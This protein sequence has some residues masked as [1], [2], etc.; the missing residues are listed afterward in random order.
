VILVDSSVLIDFLEGREN[1]AVDRLSEALDSGIPFGISPI[2]FL[3]ILQGAATDR[4]FERLRE[5]LGTQTIY[6]LKGGLDSY[7]AAA[8]LFR[9]LRKKGL[10]VGSSVD[11]L[12]ARTAIEHGLYLLHNDSDFDRIA[13]VAPLKIW[14]ENRPKKPR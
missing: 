3:E 7:A 9:A 14:G 4:D 12:I 1:A 11:C 8:D 10:S 2:T 13:R 5:Y 6:E